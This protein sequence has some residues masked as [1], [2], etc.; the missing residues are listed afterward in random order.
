MRL[1]T[2]F[3]PIHRYSISYV[4]SVLKPCLALYNQVW[5]RVNGATADDKGAIAG[6]A[7][8]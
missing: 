2:V 1:T 7:V 6:N 4:V 8:V 5:T 3:P